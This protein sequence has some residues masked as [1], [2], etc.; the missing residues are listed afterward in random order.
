MSKENWQGKVNYRWVEAGDK[1]FFQQEYAYIIL[2]GVKHFGKI[3]E[4]F[5]MYYDEPVWEHTFYHL[6]QESGC[7]VSLDGVVDGFEGWGYCV[8][9]FP[10]ITGELE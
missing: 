9:E 2:N 10:T 6:G 7:G 8:F 5:W 1:D 3:E 4:Y